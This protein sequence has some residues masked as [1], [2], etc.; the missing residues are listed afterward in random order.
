MALSSPLLTARLVAATLL[1]AMLSACG[2]GDGSNDGRLGSRILSMIQPSDDDGQV[3]GTE[4]IRREIRGL[5]GSIATVILGDQGN[6]LRT[7]Q[8][9][10][11][12]K[13]EFTN[14]P[15]GPVR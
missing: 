2:G 9:D 7:T 1:L 5:N 6:L 15:Y 14:V 12:G 10:S 11:E 3:V 4:T 8:T 13:F